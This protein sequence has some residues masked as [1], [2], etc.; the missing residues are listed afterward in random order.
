MSD[1]EESPKRE[2]Q[3]ARESVFEKRKLV[4]GHFL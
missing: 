1:S 4:E 3:M 2:G